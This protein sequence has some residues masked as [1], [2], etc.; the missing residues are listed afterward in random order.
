MLLPAERFA[1]LPDSSS[2]LEGFKRSGERYVIAA[3]LHGKLSS[4][5][6]DG[7]A[8]S[9]SKVLKASEHDANVILVADTDL[10]ADPLWVRT[11][12]VF[13]QPFFVAW[14]NNGDFVA[15][16]LDNLGGSADL[17]SIRG[18]QSFFR[19]FTRVE[20]LRHQADEQLRA[21][22]QELDRELQETERQLTDLQA[23]R[24]G[25]GSLVLSPEQEAELQRF[26]QQRMRIRQELRE[27]KRGLDI[28]IER[29]GSVLKVVN[30]ALVPTLLALGALVI[31]IVRRRRLRSGRMHSASLA[32]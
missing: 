12:N 16:A 21:K 14:A 15:N 10:L 18:R 24:K 7:L 17:I 9:D 6:P 26:Q 23:A 28:E 3:R 8:G 32:G 27:V 1:F 31:A 5:F 13:G 29:L 30:I 11:Q 20:A 19:P 2:L 4:A 22:E 25:S